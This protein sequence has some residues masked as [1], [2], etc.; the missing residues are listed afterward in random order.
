MMMLSQ[1]NRLPG[2]YPDTLSSGQMGKA[3]QVDVQRK[4]VDEVFKS[5][6]NGVELEQSDPGELALDVLISY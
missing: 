1:R 3:K 6:D 5:L 4:Q 2:Q